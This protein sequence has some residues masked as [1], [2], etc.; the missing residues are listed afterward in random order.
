MNTHDQPSIH[1]EE[2][3][4]EQC[5]KVYLKATDFQ[6]L[7]IDDSELHTCIL[8]EKKACVQKLGTGFN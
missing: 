4:P 7:D 5:R 1:A 2:E 3:L 6:L 8:E